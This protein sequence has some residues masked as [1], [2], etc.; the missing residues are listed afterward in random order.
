M[1]L[2]GY[3]ISICVTPC[4]EGV[5]RIRM[6]YSLFGD[7]SI[8]VTPSLEGVSRIRMGYA[9]YGD[10]LG[11]TLLGGCFKDYDGI[12]LIWRYFASDP[13]WRVF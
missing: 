13:A 5:S 4:L 7:I 1:P 11:Q 2:F 10:I 12:C 6:G 3:Y 8:C 9:L